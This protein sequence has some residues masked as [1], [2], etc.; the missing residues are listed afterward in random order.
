MI[1]AG[2]FKQVEV[3]LESRD[4]FPGGLWLGVWGEVGNTVCEG[5]GGLKATGLG[6]GF[7]VRPQ[8]GCRVLSGG[9]M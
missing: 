9:G 4:S 2:A 1:H 6:F 3:R 8:R 7:K 5:G